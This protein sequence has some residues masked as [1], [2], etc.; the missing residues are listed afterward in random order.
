MQTFCSSL[1]ERWNIEFTQT[2]LCWSIYCK[3][4]V[5]VSCYPYIKQFL[6]SSGCWKNSLCLSRK[7][8]IYPRIHLGALFKNPKFIYSY[9]ETQAQG[10]PISWEQF[11]VV[12]NVGTTRLQGCLGTGI[13]NTSPTIQA[14]SQRGEGQT[15]TFREHLPA[16]SLVLNS[17]CSS[18]NSPSSPN[19]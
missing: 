14:C 10:H 9:G 15:L 16:P 17:F 7:C 19:G 5:T 13:I 12:F 11:N 18:F 2:F 3:S 1:P 8:T 6:L 4:L